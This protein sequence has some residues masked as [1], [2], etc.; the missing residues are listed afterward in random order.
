MEK[1]TYKYVILGGGVCGLSTAYELSKAHPGEILVLEKDEI[2]GGLCKTISRN[3]SRYDLGS[4]RIHF[5]TP[6]KSLKYIGDL[7]DKEVIK[8]TRG[9]KLKLN[10][11]FILYPI[12]S[13]QFFLSLGLVESFKCGISLLTYRF[14]AFF[15]KKEKYTDYETYL[16][17]KA[18]KRAYQIFYEPYARKVWGCD[19]KTIDTCAVKK[20]MSMTNPIIFIKD[21][22]KHF[23][24]KN[25][26]G[27]YYYLSHGIGGFSE[28]M[29]KKLYEKNAK[30]VTNVNDF[31]LKEIDGKHQII[32]STN[33]N[34]KC[35]IT[36]EKLISTIPIDELILK[37]NPAK[38]ILDIV[39]KVRWRGL[40][41]AYIHLQEEPLLP[42]ETFYFPEIKYIFG[43]ISIPKRFSNFMQADQ[44][45][46]GFVCEVPCSPEDEKWNMDPKEIFKRCHNDLIKANLVKNGNGVL[47]EK[48]FI[49][50]L[51]KVYPLFTIGWQKTISHLLEYLQKNYK[52]IYTSG[53]GGFFMHCNMDHSVEIGV[54]LAEHLA[55]GKE[56]ESWYENFYKFHSLKLRD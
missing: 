54:R 36:Y 47:M 27:S 35:T 43:R 14:V 55:N 22:L 2:V 41:L 9:G 8:N 39:E 18:G 10:N 44:N 50:D 16:I 32:F 42:G 49:I 19:P 1:L 37:L 56:A 15:N 6:E 45:H 4:H 17:N 38:E 31:E 11:S 29:E 12:K 5:Q 46:T 7:S 13:F 34:G 28:G 23:F 25:N 48:N 3:D 26:T 52:H 21:I 53:K 40:K 20:R 51:P 30:I 24:G 33:V